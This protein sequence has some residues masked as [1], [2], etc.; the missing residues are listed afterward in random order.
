MHHVAWASFNTAASP[1]LRVTIST[2]ART[3]TGTKQVG[4]SEIDAYLLWISGHTLWD[5]GPFSSVQQCILR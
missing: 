4:P 5:E 1:Q 3:G 2:R